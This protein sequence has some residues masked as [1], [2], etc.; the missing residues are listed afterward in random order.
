MWTTANLL[1]HNE[2]SIGAVICQSKI[3]QLPQQHTET[4]DAQFG[5]I[6][7]LDTFNRPVLCLSL[8]LSLSLCS[9]DSEFNLLLSII[10]PRLRWNAVCQYHVDALC[11]FYVRNTTS[12][13]YTVVIIQREKP[14]E[15]PCC[16]FISTIRLISFISC[17]VFFSLFVFAISLCGSSLELFAYIRFDSIRVSIALLYSLWHRTVCDADTNNKS[18]WLPSWNFPILIVPGESEREEH[19]KTQHKPNN[20]EQ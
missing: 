15:I 14:Y 10:T 11:I 12:A 19:K 13:T 16:H 3:V 6:N 8:S 5:R 9:I 2:R 20:L 17:R 18:D 1:E 7:K 4:V